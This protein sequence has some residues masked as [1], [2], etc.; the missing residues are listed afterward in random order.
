MAKII[1]EIEM[2]DYTVTLRDHGKKHYSARLSSATYGGVLELERSDYGVKIRQLDIGSAE[3]QLEHLAL[4]AV[5]IDVDQTLVKEIGKIN[6]IRKPRK[7]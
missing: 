3:V 2:G 7:D 4:M 6:E 5:L 1:K